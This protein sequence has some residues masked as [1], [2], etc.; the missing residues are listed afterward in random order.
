[1]KLYLVRHGQTDSNVKVQLTGLNDAPLNDLGIKQAKAVVP[2][3]PEGI[4]AIYCSPLIRTQQTAEILNRKLGLPLHLTP[5]LNERDFGSLTEKSWDEVGEDL[6]RIDREQRFDYRP[7]GGE[8][9]ED[10]HGRLRS[11]IADLKTEKPYEKVL[12]VTSSGVIR[13]LY[14]LRDGYLPANTEELRNRFSNASV[15]EYII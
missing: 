14:Y 12:V 8:A 1:M 9:V 15:H 4:Q 5:L 11:F 3:L 10:V 2:L 6:R 7:Y 13:A